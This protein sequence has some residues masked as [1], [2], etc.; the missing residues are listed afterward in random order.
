[1]GNTFFG[2]S[3]FFLLFLKTFLSTKFKVLIVDCQMF[4]M[5]MLRFSSYH[6]SDITRTELYL[7]LKPAVK[8]GVLGSLLCQ[9]LDEKWPQR[10]TMFPSRGGDIILCNC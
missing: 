4:K 8:S 1:M 7:I 3:T 2:W 10:G 9:L 6:K 5:A